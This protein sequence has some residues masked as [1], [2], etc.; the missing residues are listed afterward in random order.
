MRLSRVFSHMGISYRE[1]TT[2]PKRQRKMLTR[3]PA[4]SQTSTTMP[5]TCSMGAGVGGNDARSFLW[6]WQ[7]HAIS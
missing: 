3:G 2:R 6:I 1:H 4:Q 5:S 7:R